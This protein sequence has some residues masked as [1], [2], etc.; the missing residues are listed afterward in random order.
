MCC[1]CG[2]SG[3]SCSLQELT[4]WKPFSDWFPQTVLFL[5]LF[6]DKGRRVILILFERLFRTV[7][8]C[9]ND[10]SSPWSNEAHMPQTP[11]PDMNTY[12]TSISQ[13]PWH[14]VDGVW[15]WANPVPGK[16]GT[17]GGSRGGASSQDHPQRVSETYIYLYYM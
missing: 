9:L 13:S 2:D 3:E 16:P 12:N 1:V 4:C 8:G 6:Q 5:G 14:G 7:C 15:G 11:N 17:F 10:R